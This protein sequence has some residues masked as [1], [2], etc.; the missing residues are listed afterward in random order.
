MRTAH[1]WFERER[2]FAKDIEQIHGKHKSG[3]LLTLFLLLFVAVLVE[4]V[5]FLSSGGRDR[6]LRTWNEREARQ[7]E[8]ETRRLAYLERAGHLVGQCGTRCLW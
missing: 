1:V 6:G 8:C 4:H 5:G 2:K 3:A 7:N